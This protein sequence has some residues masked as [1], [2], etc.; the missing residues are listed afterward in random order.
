MD[1]QLCPDF[2]AVLTYISDY[3]S[4]DDSGTMKFILDALK[5]ARNETLAKQLSIVAHKFLTHRQIEEV[6]AYY[7]LLPHL[8]MKE[9]NIETVFVATG[10]REKKKQ[11]QPKNKSKSKKK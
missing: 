3:F 7:R 4:K 10:F 2:Y 5:D 9:S 1:L 11:M 6:E 8:H